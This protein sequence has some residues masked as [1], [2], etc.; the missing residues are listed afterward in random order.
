MQALLSLE[1]TAEYL[2]VPVRTLRAFVANGLL[3]ALYPLGNQLREDPRFRADEVATFAEARK[4]TPGFGEVAAMAKMA[5]FRIEALQRQVER[6]LEVIGADI[7][8]LDC[9]EAAVL[10]LSSEIYELDQNQHLSIDSNFVFHWARIFYA[11]G[12]EYFAALSYYTAE[13][14]PWVRPLRFATKI[15]EQKPQLHDPE[16][17]TA[18]RYLLLGR[19]FMRQAAYFYV[20][21]QH[22]TRR[23]H[24]LFREVTGDINTKILSVVF[25]AESQP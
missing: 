15:F 7:P 12:E 2:G 25:A 10:M 17:D 20:R 5:D 13:P 18:Y 21:E 8:T 16:L 11:M 3:K 24:Q 6:L 22:G 4:R 14:E 9:T 19:R 23:A 1:E